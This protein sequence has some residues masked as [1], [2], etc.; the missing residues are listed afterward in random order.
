MFPAMSDLIYLMNT[1]V[2]KDGKILVTD[3]YKSVAPLTETEKKLYTTIDFDTEA[4][5]YVFTY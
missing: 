2:D 1:L 5:K 4:Y 3:V